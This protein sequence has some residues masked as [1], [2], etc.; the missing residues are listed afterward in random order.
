MP[1]K[2]KP[3]IN[4]ADVWDFEKNLALQ[5]TVWKNEAIKLRYSCE[6][7]RHNN[8]H[9]RKVIFDK[10][11]TAITPNF[12]STGVERMLLGFSLE[13]LIKAVILQEE[14]HQETV[15]KNTGKLS[16]ERKGHDLIELFE[17]ADVST[18]EEEQVY[19]QLWQTCAVWAGRYPLPVSK[20][21]LTAH[22]TGAGSRKELEE[23]AKERRKRAMKKGQP[24][25]EIQDLLTTDLT[26]GEFAV[27]ER[28][29]DWRMSKLA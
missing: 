2:K 16:W 6:I 3:Y 15:F 21:G 11:G 5:P 28:L 23:R 25:P 14:K 1:E 20:N 19:L 22:R 13:N 17:T 10:K 9:L 12:C 8:E 7:L 24:L 4:P 18:S 26:N 27:F 29:Y